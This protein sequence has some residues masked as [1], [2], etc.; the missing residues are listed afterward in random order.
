MSFKSITRDTLD[1]IHSNYRNPT[2]LPGAVPPAR[3]DDA[4][5]RGVGPAN[6][7]PPPG[8]IPPPDTGPVMLGGPRPPVQAPKPKGP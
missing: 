4:A 2:V 1:A 3:G 8:P 7:D 5:E 6:I